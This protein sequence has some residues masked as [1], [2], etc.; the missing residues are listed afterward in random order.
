MSNNTWGK[1][2]GAVERNTRTFIGI[3]GSESDELKYG[4][5]KGYECS[6]RFP[7]TKGEEGAVTTNIYNQQGEIVK[8][9]TE[10]HRAELVDVMINDVSFHD[11]DTADGRSF[12]SMNI[13]LTSKTGKEV[14]LSIPVNSSY[15]DNL[16]KALPAI[17]LEKPVTLSPYNFLNEGGKVVS[18]LSIKQNGAKVFSHYNDFDP[19]TKK[20]TPKN[21]FP[22]MGKTHEEVN[23][24]TPDRKKLF[25][26]NY[27]A[28]ASIF[29]K[30]ETEKNIVPKFDAKRA[31][32]Q[33]D[34]IEYPTEDLGGEIDF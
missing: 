14:V 24:M 5:Q 12:T 13:G 17:N 23:A 10:Q 22:G 33:P 30:E 1:E 3:R 15:A 18:G 26:K 6:F 11:V 32:A 19:E 25:W 20:S 7:A 8:E 31:S 27:F 16:M 2:D 21:G 28:E 34:K 29:L 4:K 9:K